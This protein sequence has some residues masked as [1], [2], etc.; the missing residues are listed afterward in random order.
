L[1]THGRTHEDNAHILKKATQTA[2]KWADEN[3][4]AFND[5]KSEMLHFHHTCQDTTPDAINITLPNGII[6]KPGIQEGRKDV[7]RWIG[8][9][10]DCKL[11][12]THHINAKLISASRSFNALC[13]LVQHETGL[14]PSATCSL[15]YTY[16]QY[17]SDFGTEIWWTG[18]KTF[19]NCLQT[20]QNATLC[21][22]LNAFHSTPIIALHNKAALPPISIHLQ[23]K[24]TKYVLYLLTLPPSHPVIK[25]CPSSFPVPNHLSTTL[26]DTNKYDFDWTQN[27]HP[28]SQLG[29]ALCT[30][31]PWVHPNANV[32]DTA[33]P[34]TTPWNVPTI[35]IDIQNLPK[36]KAATAHLSLLHNLH[37]NPHNVIAYTDSSQLSTQT[38]AGFYNPY[39]LPNPIRTIIPLGTTSEV[40]DMEL[41]AITEYLHTCLKYIK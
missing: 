33:Q 25:C 24:Q 19:M 4:V 7:I 27:Y 6:M 39:G 21:C 40:F 20:Q 16:I 10:F 17:R 13:S 35:T 29:K 28:P 14:S 41:K 34:T 9:L 1:V 30:L 2:F 18:Q 22:I 38:G 36:D 15:Y 12:F 31:S 8:I 26:C 32:E 37:N 5:S 11:R 3:A 23:S